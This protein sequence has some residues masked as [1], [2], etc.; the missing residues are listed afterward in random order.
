MYVVR[1]DPQVTA[2][3][4]DRLEARE[5]QARMA[6]QDVTATRDRKEFKDQRVN[7]DPQASQDF[8]VSKGI[9]DFLVWM[10]LRETLE[11][12]EQRETPES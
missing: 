8:P 3:R 11:S 12:K 1:W 4:Q 5:H 9:V 7:V 10:E 6:T 2:D